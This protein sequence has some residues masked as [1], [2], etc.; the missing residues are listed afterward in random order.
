[1]RARASGQNWQSIASKH[2]PSKSDNACRK[3][4][5]R[6]MAQKEAEEWKGIKLEKL[7]HEWH[8]L[9]KDIWTPLADRLDM[10]WHVVEQIV[11]FSSITTG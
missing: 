7:V 5:E 1:M 10:K 2:F 4:H 9:R 3:R 11:C 8:P 6:L